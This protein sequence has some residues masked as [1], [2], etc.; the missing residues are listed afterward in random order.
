[1]HAKNLLLA[2]ACFST[3][4]HLCFGVLFLDCADCT[5]AEQ[6]VSAD[7]TMLWQM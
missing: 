1:M 4:A 7:L 2:L 5:P 3:F 6:L